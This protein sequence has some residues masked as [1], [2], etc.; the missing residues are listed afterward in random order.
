MKLNF[1]EQLLVNNRVRAVVQ[2]F[3]EAP[4]FLRLGGTVP[5]GTVLEIGCGRGAGIE[6]ILRQFEAAHVC[7]IDLDPLQVERARKRL[8]GKYPGLV[9]LM[10]GDAEQLPFANASF[11]AVF[12][13]GALHHVP[14]WQ[15]SIAEIRRVLKP[16]GTFFFEEV[17]RAALQRW[18]YRRFLD[19]PA[20]NRFSEAE[21]MTETARH[22]LKPAGPLRRTLFGDIFIGVAKL[23]QP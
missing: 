3:Y 18:I 9:T 22:G 7:G 15:K 6:V 12:D 16:G 8:Q 17:T 21:F 11:D 4:L 5:G 2:V 13:F 10:Q 14:D 23:S 19:H 20:D 1:A